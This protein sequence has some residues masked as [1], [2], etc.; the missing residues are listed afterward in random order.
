MEINNNVIEKGSSAAESS[1]QTSSDS[2]S[3]TE[4]LTESESQVN[5]SRSL[6]VNCSSFV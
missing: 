6:F 3:A 5:C 2:S 4:Q 1:S